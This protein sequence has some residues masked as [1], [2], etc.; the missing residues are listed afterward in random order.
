MSRRNRR[1][2]AR[3]RKT[4][5]N[6]KKLAAI[7][8]PVLVLALGGAGMSYYLGIEKID[9]NYCYTREDQHQH[10][11]FLDTSM[12][13]LSKAQF[14]DYR[15]AY[16]DA[17]E[18]APANTKFLFFSTQADRTGSLAKPLHVVCKPP[19]TTAEL[20][21]IGA[22]SVSPPKL[23]KQA[24][25][26]ETMFR[27]MVEDV[28]SG[29]EES[30]KRSKDSP[31]LETIQEISKY[32]GFQNPVRSLTVITDGIQNSEIARFCSMRGDM[33]SFAKFKAR[34]DYRYVKPK[35]LA[36]VDVTM[37][38]VESVKLPQPGLSFCTTAEM[39]RWWPEFFEGNEAAS[40]DLR[41][42]RFGAN[43]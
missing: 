2:G 39:R 3:R 41:R 4:Q 26:A 16:S 37:F 38:L 31:I 17:Y 23:K 25:K 34:N 5:F 10:A 40:V 20:E 8:L 32:R 33:P 11:V 12:R 22:P 27:A 6:I 14:R 19:Q 24:D 21:A 43:S 42:L 30:S 1:R 29:A 15:T 28:L 18:A 7:S 36:D 9:E 35:S 13:T